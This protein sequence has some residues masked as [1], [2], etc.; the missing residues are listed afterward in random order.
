MTSRR[1]F[2]GFPKAVPQDLADALRRPSQRTGSTGHVNHVPRYKAPDEDAMPKQPNAHAVDRPSTYYVRH[3]PEK[4]RDWI[5]SKASTTDQHFTSDREALRS[6][7]ERAKA[8]ILKGMPA[9][10]RVE[11]A[12]GS[13]RVIDP[14]SLV[15]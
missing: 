2:R 3:P 9:E 8:D 10:V 11:E 1:C 13:W 14:T 12:D 5:V 7:L 4:G 15:P 6:A